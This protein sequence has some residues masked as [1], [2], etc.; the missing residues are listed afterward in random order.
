MGQKV[1]HCLQCHDDPEETFSE[2]E[3]RRSKDGGGQR[4]RSSGLS[5]YSN[6]LRHVIE[7]PLKIGAF[8]VRRFGTAKMKDKE[9]VDILVRI[10]KQFDVIVIQEIVDTKETAINELVNAVNKSNI[11]GKSGDD[12]KFE[13][14]FKLELS[15][16]VGRNKQKEQYGLIYRSTKLSVEESCIYPDPGDIFIREPFI[17]KFS[18]DAVNGINGFTIISVH[19]Q[20]KVKSDIF[21]KPNIST[22]IIECSH[23][24]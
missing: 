21:D 16:R 8:N 12:G 20:P 22:N 11:A 6:D 9:V 4:R 13:N 23:R 1:S 2:Q 24:N 7:E 5:R 18:T 14:V 3:R 10:I 19:T 15:P 17:V